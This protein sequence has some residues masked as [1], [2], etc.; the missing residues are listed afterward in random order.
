MFMPPSARPM[1][2]RKE[3]FDQ[4]ECTEGVP[5]IWVGYGYGVCAERSELMSGDI[6]YDAGLTLSPGIWES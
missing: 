6:D 2:P 3:V 4:A 5:A 1:K